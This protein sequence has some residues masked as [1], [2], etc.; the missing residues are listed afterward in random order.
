M[1]IKIHGPYCVSVSVCVCVCVVRVCVVCGGFGGLIGDLLCLYVVNSLQIAAITRMVWSVKNCAVTV[2]T[3]NRVITW[4]EPV[5][6]DVS[7]GFT[8]IN[9]IKVM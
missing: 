9:V 5:H 2:A 3:G 8:E 4:T 7:R 6:T 1:R